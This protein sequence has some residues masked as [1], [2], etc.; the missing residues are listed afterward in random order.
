MLTIINDEFLERRYRHI[1][2]DFDST[3]YLWDNGPERKSIESTVWNARQLSRQGDAYDPSNINHLLVA[4]LEQ[5]GAEAHLLT[6]VDFSFEA[7]SKFNFI[8]RHYPGLLAD[9]IGT[10][11]NEDKVR[12][13]EAYEHAGNPKE[14]MLVIDDNFNVVRSCRERGFDVQEPQFVMGQMYRWKHP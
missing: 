7:E 8:N 4:Y 12:L 2:V 1:F 9:Y 5:S 10:K 14:A 3:L 13:L 6:W 11:S